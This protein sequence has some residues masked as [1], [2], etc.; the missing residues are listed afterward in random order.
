MG[1][2]SRGY[3]DYCSSLP[4]LEGPRIRAEGD[5]ADGKRGLLSKVVEED[6]RRG[7]LSKV[8][9]EDVVVE[10]EEIVGA[11]GSS[12]SS[13]SGTYFTA[14]DTEEVEEV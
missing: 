8:E 1:G 11:V 3:A 10:S 14:T 12:G 6:G 4:A 7:L 2:W 13:G 9:E 5:R